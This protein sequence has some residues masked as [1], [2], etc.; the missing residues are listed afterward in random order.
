MT[1][2]E[3]GAEQLRRGDK[4]QRVPVRRGLGD[5]VGADQTGG[6]GSRIDHHLLAQGL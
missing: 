2:I 3:H 6:A 5:D 4:P 1:L